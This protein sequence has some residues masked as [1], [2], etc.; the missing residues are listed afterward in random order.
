MPTLG[1]VVRSTSEDGITA[2]RDIGAVD[3]V[4]G[5]NI[6]PT[7][8]SAGQ[9]DAVVERSVKVGVLCKQGV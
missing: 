6:G 9:E 2:I 5:N 3:M 8:D 7:V 4:K 1:G